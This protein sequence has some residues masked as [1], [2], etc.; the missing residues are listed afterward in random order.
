MSSCSLLDEAHQTLDA[1]RAYIW[2]TVCVAPQPYCGS[3]PVDLRSCRRSCGTGALEYL[4]NGSEVGKRTRTT[5]CVVRV[6]SLQL[7]AVYLRDLQLVEECL[8]S[9]TGCVDDIV[10][11]LNSLAEDIGRLR[12]DLVFFD[13]SYSRY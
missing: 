13:G 7:V 6:E 3:L 4:R 11:D 9:A 8:R 1:L 12:G 5:V 10:S 2:G